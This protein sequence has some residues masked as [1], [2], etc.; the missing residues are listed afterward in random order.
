MLAAMAGVAAHTL[1]AFVTYEEAA[2]NGPRYHC[3]MH[4]TVVS[5]RPGECPICHMDLVPIADERSGKGKM[6]ELPR[7][8]VA[9]ATGV[10][11]ALDRQ[12]LGGVRT[13]VATEE[14]VGGSLRVPA[15]VVA[16]EH[17]L[18]RLH[19]RAAG[20]LE[21]VRA[22]QTGVRV[23]RGQVLA[24]IYSPEVY[25]AAQE[26]II[27]SGL[28]RSGG[29]ASMATPE[30]ATAPVESPAFGPG[31]VQAAR[32]RLELLGLTS[33]EIHDIVKSGKAPRRHALRAPRS[34][35]IVAKTAVEGAYVTPE[36]ELYEIADLDRVW[37]IGDVREADLP[38]GVLGRAARFSD[39]APQEAIE[40]VGAIEFVYPE[41]RADT[42]TVRV[43]MEVDNRTLG[44]MP[45][46]YGDL[47]IEAPA[48]KE[49]TVPRD[50]LVATGTE[51]YVF[52]ARGS[53]IFEPRL[54]EIG[55]RQGEH[56]VIAKGLVAGDRV[57]SGATFL[58]DSES[59]LRAALR[60]VGDVTSRDPAAAAPSAP[61]SPA[62][63]G[64]SN[65]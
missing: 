40:A 36:S 5:D 16:R 51:T 26:L 30:G 4:P 50:A 10:F 59:R 32:K 13:S 8:D 15:Y 48:R 31:G 29:P 35:Y 18:E 20:F 24:E 43:R 28:L 53:G 57:V 14:D 62:T 34:G 33:G 1:Y 19:T 2:S 47:T 46:A 3:P 42:R 49:L 41:V 61:T 38:R 27:A 7:G 37:I 25:A 17:T 56:V 12:Q 60:S 23:K 9:G 55:P 44:L 45:G 52:L 64:H 11:L 39:R 63:G 65:H 22:G 21:K 58:V 54:V 6:A